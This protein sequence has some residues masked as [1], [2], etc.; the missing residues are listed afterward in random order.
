VIDQQ[1]SIS[2][3][4]EHNQLLRL[5]WDAICTLS[6]PQQKAMLF[7]M[8]VVQG[9]SALVLFQLTGRASLPQLA[10]ALELSVEELEAMSEQLPLKDVEIAARLGITRQQVI[11]LRKSARERL[12][13]ANRT[14]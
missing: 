6:K 1:F 8:R 12:V 11:N 14:L 2:T 10:V 4:Y 5:I 3:K 9:R 13:A 7:G